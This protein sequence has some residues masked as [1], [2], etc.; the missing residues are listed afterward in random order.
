MADLLTLSDRIDAEFEAAR[1]RSSTLANQ[2]ES[3][4]EGRWKRLEQVEKILVETQSLWRDRLSKMGQWFGDR[5]KLDAQMSV[6]GRLA[7]FWVRSPKAEIVLRFSILTD[8]D[9]R[10]VIYQYDLDIVPPEF[11]YDAHSELVFPID[12]IDQHKLVDWIYERMISFG[13]TYIEMHE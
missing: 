6:G 8:E 10:H 2:G 3:W 5:V 13:K 1:K 4:S 12:K 11:V 9:V 7:K